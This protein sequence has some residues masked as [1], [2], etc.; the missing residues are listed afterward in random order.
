MLSGVSLFD[1]YSYFKEIRR[2]TELDSQI[3][4]SWLPNASIVQTQGHDPFSWSSQKAAKQFFNVLV[5]GLKPD[6]VVETGVYVGAS[7]VLI[8]YATRSETEKE[9]FTHWISARLWT[10]DPGLLLQASLFLMT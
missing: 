10:T 6:T 9:N 4:R 5:R 3:E 1:V 8:L 2:T 7:N